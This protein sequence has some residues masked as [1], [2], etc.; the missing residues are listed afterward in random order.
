MPTTLSERLRAAQEY[1]FVGRTGELALFRS[2]IRAKTLRFNILYIYGPG[3]IGKTTLLNKF[4][5]ICRQ[6]ALPTTYIDSRSIEPTPVSFLE[7]LKQALA[8]ES[9]VLPLDF[10]ASESGRRII[11]IDTCELLG[12][13]GEWLISEFL[14]KVSD[15]VLFVMAGREPPPKDWLIDPAWHFLIHVLSLRNFLPEESITY[16]QKRTVPRSQ[17]TAVLQFTHGHPLA[18][19]LVA[20]VFAQRGEIQLSLDDIPNVVRTLLQRFMQQVPGPAH[21]AALEICALVRVTTESLL[22]VM[23]AQTDVH[24]IFEWLRGLSF[25][26]SRRGGIFPHDLARE[27]LSADLRWRNPDWYGEL[28]RRARE[29]YVSHLE[30]TSGQQQLRVLW[31]YIYLHRDN[32]IIKPYFDWQT[33]GSMVVDALGGQD[34]AVLVAMVKKHEG[35]ES[36]HLASHWFAFCPENTVVLRD[37]KGQATGFLMWIELNRLSEENRRTDPAIRIAWDYLRKYAPLRPGEIAMHFR[38]WMAV[39]TYQSVSMI[40]S[41]IFVNMVR[42]YLTTPNLAF[43]FTYCADPAFW[44]P[45]FAYADQPLLPEAEFEIGGH[46]YG[47]FGHD[48]RVRPPLAWLDLLAEQEVSTGL[49]EVSQPSKVEHLV[50]LSHQDFEQAVRE[51]LRDFVYPDQLRNNPIL[52]S[53]LVFSHVGADA[54]VDARLQALS[55]LLLQTA[56]SLRASPRTDKFFRALERTYFHPAPTQEIS[57]QL[58]NLPLSTYRRHLRKGIRHITNSLWQQELGGGLVAK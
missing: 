47:T 2:V 41:V 22:A 4:M 19:S 12:N 56:K 58:L 51:A 36:A 49:A 34:V 7:A 16:L 38:Y 35:Q 46:R 45:A 9:A 17:H 15:K 18:L 28:H 8:P 43:T 42:Y 32:P 24:E 27:T 21:R 5:Q 53:R 57:A 1:Y 37:T 33:K 40:Q 44:T 54:D 48:W 6:T 23:L 55:K 20:D 10:L 52:R 13:L 29:Y 39:E 11:I 31:D 14:P 30:Q 25:I 3:G 26:E 50:V